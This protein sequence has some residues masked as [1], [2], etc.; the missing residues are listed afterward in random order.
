MCE[1][2]T[3]ADWDARTSLSIMHT[4]KHFHTYRQF[5]VDSPP[6]VMALACERKPMWTCENSTQTG[7]RAR[8][9]TEL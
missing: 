5:S 4:P 3:H 6:T 9:Q 1:A 8:D 7:I 2:V